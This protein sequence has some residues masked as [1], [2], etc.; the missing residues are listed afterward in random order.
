MFDLIYKYYSPF[1]RMHRHRV[2][3]DFFEQ[4]L[5]HQLICFQILVS[6]CNVFMPYFCDVLLCA[7]F[8]V[9]GIVPTDTVPQSVFDM[10][11]PRH[12]SILPT[13]AGLSEVPVWVAN[14]FLLSYAML[15]TYL[16]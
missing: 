4:L 13:L 15:F 9:L 2:I 14:I 3:G 11:S 5:V 8:E 6:N 10:H 12:A 1:L 16:K 7:N